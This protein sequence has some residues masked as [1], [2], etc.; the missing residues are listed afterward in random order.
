MH[1]GLKATASGCETH[2]EQGIGNSTARV[3]AA[4]SIGT[5]FEW[6]DFTLYGALATVIAS[7]F[8]AGVD[9]T[10]G[11]IF[12][13]LTFGVG[14]IMR[15]VGAVIFGRIGDKIGRKRTFLVTI[16]IMGIST[17][18]VGCLPGYASIGIAAPIILISLRML[19]GLALGGEYGGAATY[20]AEHSPIKRRGFNTSWISATGTIGLLMSFAV[21][22]ATRALTGE[23]FEVWGWRLPFIFSILLLLISLLIRMRMEE[24]PAFQALKS[25]NRLSR[26]P[27]TETFLEWTNIKRLLV[28]LFAICGGMTC[29]YYTAV[30]LPTFFLTHTLKVDASAANVVVTLATLVCTPL[31]LLAGWLCDRFGRKPVLMTSFLLMAVTIFPIFHAMTRYANPALAQAQENVPV[32]VEADAKTCSFMFNPTGSRK[33]TS[34]CDIAR[35]ALT[36]AGVSYET[37]DAAAGQQA[38]VHVGDHS[39]RAY[40]A[41]GLSAADAK[42][43]STSFL[44]ALRGNLDSAGFPRS[45]APEQFN[46]PMVFV[47]LVILLALMTLALVPTGP[48]LVEMFPT[49]IRYTSMS[50]P[51]HFAS[52]WIG[53]LL[54]T[55][56]FALSA[57]EGNIYFGLWYPFGWIVLS[58]V[59]AFFFLRETK[60]VDLSADY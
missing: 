34:S 56:S 58:L 50:F 54:P 12:A 24:S 26:A 1:S 30:L 28:A 15:P 27:L 7:R 2:A 37:R 49:R 3:I 47:L 5:V 32:W 22:L 46:K 43:Q 57:Q 48:A 42:L 23:N 31:F 11:F 8:F 36:D 6:Y 25:G 44:K 40:D 52:G 38:T 60:D 29:V 10:T 51:Y 16:I 59:V 4:A 41:S 21:V 20:V 39:I 45:A 18:G 9:S 19:Q 35:Q 14:F 53:G 17:V 33:F 55:I 13:L